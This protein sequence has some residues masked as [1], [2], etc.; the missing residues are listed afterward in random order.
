MKKII[1]SLLSCVLILSGCSNQPSAE[2]LAIQ[3]IREEQ[4][5]YDFLANGIYEVQ[6]LKYL[7]QIWDNNTY[8]YSK[9]KVNISNKLMNEYFPTDEWQGNIIASQQITANISSIYVSSISDEEITFIFILTKEISG[10]TYYCWYEAVYD[11]GLS[12]IIKLDLIYEL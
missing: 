1:A 11:L 6:Q 3:A 12:Q 9:T 8:Q 2:E 4:S 7:F 5:K 10:L